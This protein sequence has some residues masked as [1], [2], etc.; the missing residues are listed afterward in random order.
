MGQN[1]TIKVSGPGDDVGFIFW[2]N[3]A[4]RFGVVKIFP[5]VSVTKTRSRWDLFP[6]VWCR[7][8]YEI[9][10]YAVSRTPKFEHTTCSRREAGCSVD[11]ILKFPIMRCVLC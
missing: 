3:L 6:L 1:F 5:A 4:F 2:V 10:E 8:V 11:D 7:Q 9:L